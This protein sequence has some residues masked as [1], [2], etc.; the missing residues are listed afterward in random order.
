MIHIFVR[1]KS[2]SSLN[3]D[4]YVLIKQVLN[5]SLKFMNVKTAQDAHFALS[6]Q[7]QKRGIIENQGE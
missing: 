1:I 4:P 3:I 2:I 7:K 6:V 5:A